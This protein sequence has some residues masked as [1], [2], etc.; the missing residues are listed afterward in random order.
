MA[1]TEAKGG[2]E[3]ATKKKKTFK[4]R[5]EKRIIH[6]GYAHIHAS[7]NNTTITITDP[8]GAAFCV[9]QAN[10]HKGATIVNEHGSLNFNGLHTRDPEG[11]KAFYGSVFGWETLAYMLFGTGMARST[12]SG[13]ATCITSLLRKVCRWRRA[14]APSAT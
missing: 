6:H 2:A 14:G 1:K 11:A 4:K 5:G 8:E 7:F 12:A 10:E 9:W 3:Q 13:A